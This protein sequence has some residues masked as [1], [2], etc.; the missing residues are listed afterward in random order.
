MTLCLNGR[1]HLG[2]DGKRRGKEAV[3]EATVLLPMH[4]S[5]RLASNTVTE[6]NLVTRVSKCYEVMNTPI[7]TRRVR[8]NNV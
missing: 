2:D 6:Q 4:V 8:R 7:E 5:T 1:I 3:A